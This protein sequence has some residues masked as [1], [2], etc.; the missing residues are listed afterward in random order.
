MQT[1]AA[2][3]IVTLTTGGPGVPVADP[4]RR[5][6]RARPHRDWTTVATAYLADP[7]AYWGSDA[8][9]HADKLERRKQ[10][11]RVDGLDD[12]AVIGEAVRMAA[13]RRTQRP[14]PVFIAGLGGSG[15][16]WLAGMLEDAADLVAAGEVYVPRTLLDELS[17][18]S[19]ADQ[20][21]VIDAVHIVH[22]WPRSA[23]VWALGIINNAAG[24]RALS[25]YLRWFPDATIVHLRRDPR[26]QV[27]SVTFRKPRFRRYMAPD[28]SDDEYLQRMIRRNV[29]AYRAYLATHAHVAVACRYE[30]LAEDPRPVLRAVLRSLRLDADEQRITRAIARHDADAI[31][32]GRSG[33]TSNLHDGGAVTWRD[34]RDPAR[35]R[36][37][38]AGLADVIHGFGYAPDDCMGTH[39]PDSHLPDRTLAFPSG[40][41]GP[42]YERRG[43][44]WRRL[45]TDRTRVHVTAGTPVLLRVGTD[46]APDLR[47]LRDLAPGDVQALCMAGNARLDDATLPHVGSMA[48]LQTLDL[49]H[50]AVS[51]A[52]LGCV[53]QLRTLQQLNVAG[54]STTAQ[55]R[56][57]LAAR[58]PQVTIW[59]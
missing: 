31:R 15:S 51:D 40:A 26:D 22:A 30:D 28:A 48:G 25:R 33:V 27:L 29:T 41:P 5:I 39:L 38:H 7:L 3:S 43:G 23:A 21:C 10:A 56:A 4:V 55:G 54:T 49:A 32:A 9:R 42:L 35:Q 34:L 14:A 8:P 45:D 59:T 50:T 47:V 2:P 46:D 24:V 6:L 19:D 11:I 20:A 17:G 1:D 57:D 53:A 36:A 18:L 13:R 58:L 16:H 12:R 37:L 52:G 44:V